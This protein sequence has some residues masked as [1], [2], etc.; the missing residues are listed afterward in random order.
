MITGGYGAALLQAVLALLAVSVLAWVVLRGLARGGMLRGGGRIRV[1]ERTP[2]DARHAL[3]LVQVDG[4]TL[5]LGVGD[6]SAP[7]LLKTL[8]ESDLPSLSGSGAHES[9]SQ[10]DRPAAAAASLS[11]AR[12]SFSAALARAKLARAVDSSREPKNDV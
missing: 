6:G 2:L 12:Q 10:G 4:E 3:V 5:L 1:L 11:G 8:P 9:G 7:T